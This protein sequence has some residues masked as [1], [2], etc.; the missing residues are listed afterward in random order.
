MAILRIPVKA[1]IIDWAIDNGEKKEL[2]L[3]KKYA[4]DAWK[5]PQT[6][7]DNP[8]FK[9]IQNFSRD[10]HIPFNYFFKDKL[11][12]EKNEFVKFRTINNDTVQ[13]SRRL[14]DTIYAMETRQ[15]WMK[16]YLLD[17]NKTISFQFSKV[18]SDTM[19]PVAVSKDVLE[20]LN[21]SDTLGIAMSDDDFFNVIRTKIS[22]L[23]IMVMQ[24]GIVGTN[25]QRPL[26]VEEFRAFV[27]IDSVIPLI[28]VNSR[29]SKKAKIFSLI[30]EL[31]HV[32]LGNNEVL[33]VSPE[34]DIANER[35]INQVTINVL[36][37]A[38]KIDKLISKKVSPENNVKLLS[39]RFHTSL[40]ATAIRMK[41]LH[42]WGDNIV[43]W[44]KKEQSKYLQL[45]FEKKS[46][47]GDFYNTAVSRI[48]RYFANAII[49]TESSGSMAI[50]QAASMLGVTLKTYDTTVDKILGMA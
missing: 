48:D 50:V 36:I 33:N 14:I 4:L 1:E 19:D 28:F 10:T 18:F 8:T 34:D 49:N 20:L 46:S 47:G 32:F 30:H 38:N 22:S 39:R 42:I 44:S 25:T 13:P 2:E 12:E 27:L 16:E 29:D 21:L 7:H 41:E 31:I 26:D 24:N 6:D 40:V 3:K 15:E 5:N 35:W 45:K 43:D 11:P 9:Q 23:G 37:P 17:Q